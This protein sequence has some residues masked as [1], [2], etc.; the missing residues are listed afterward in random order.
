MLVRLRQNIQT[1]HLFYL[2][3]LLV[4]T[5]LF[6]STGHEFMHN[7]KP[8][9]KEHSDCA[10]YQI[11]FLLNSIIVYYFFFFVTILLILFLT[12]PDIHILGTAFRCYISGRAPPLYY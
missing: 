11:G 7:H 10:A 3:Y 5:L 4:I 1:K 9:R 8:D 2:L 12:L 6:L